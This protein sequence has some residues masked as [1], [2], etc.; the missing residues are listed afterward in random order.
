MEDHEIVP[1]D[2]ATI[3]ALAE[4]A[5]QERIALSSINAART[6]TL[7]LF[8]RQNKLPGNWRLAENKRELIKAEQSVQ[9]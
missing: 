6:A 7:N 9:Q 4:I 2:D 8:A 5:I 1:L 3:E